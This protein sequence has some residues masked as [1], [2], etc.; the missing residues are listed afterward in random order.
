MRIPPS[1]ALLDA[2]TRAGAAPSGSRPGARPDPRPDNVSAAPS[3][4]ARAAAR[5]AFQTLGQTQGASATR[6]PKVLAAPSPVGAAQGPVRP[7][8]T[9]PEAAGAA[10]ASAVNPSAPGKIYPRGTFLNI[11]I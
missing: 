7:H 3:D 6:A 9:L 11:V 10:T 2:L 1:S 4:A 8:A 5:A